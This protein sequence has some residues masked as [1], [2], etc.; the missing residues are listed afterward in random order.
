MSGIVVVI[1]AQYVEGWF[2]PVPNWVVSG[3]ASST[4]TKKCQ[5]TVSPTAVVIKRQTKRYEGE[6]MVVSDGPAPR[7]RFS[8]GSATLIS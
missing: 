8:L 2:H 1:P 6:E 5:I 3:K 4:H 7:F